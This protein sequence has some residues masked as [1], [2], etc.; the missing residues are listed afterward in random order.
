MSRAGNR[1]WA[2]YVAALATIAAIVTG[3]CGCAAPSWFAHHADTGASGSDVDGT[4]NETFSDWPPY[5]K[6]R[7]DM[8]VKPTARQ[9]AI[10]KALLNDRQERDAGVAGMKEGWPDVQLFRL[11]T[12]AETLLDRMSERY[13]V[14]FQAS[15]GFHRPELLDPRW[16]INVTPTSGPLLG[17]VFEVDYVDGDGADGN[18][19]GPYVADTYFTA[20]RK[21]DYNGHLAERIE[22]FVAARSDL[23]CVYRIIDPTGPKNETQWELSPSATTDDLASYFVGSVEI[24][25]SPATPTDRERFA[26]FASAFITAMRK[27]GLAVH[28]EIAQITRIDGDEFTVDTARDAMRHSTRTPA[29][30]SWYTGGFTASAD[31][32]A[33]EIVE[34]GE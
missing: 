7:Y 3:V 29:W 25:I 1:R 28:Y 27:E 34:D 21:D 33:P 16:W 13:G 9:I 24:Y 20:L 30:D 2:A 22:R 15:E 18:D 8:D 10:A 4:G 5:A 31:A 11:I 26:S 12:L 32:S 6:Q 14:K 23:D 17:G 19:S